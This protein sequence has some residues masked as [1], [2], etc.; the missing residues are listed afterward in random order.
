MLENLLTSPIPLA[1]VVIVLSLVIFFALVM[2]VRKLAV[3]ANTKNTANFI[4][5]GLSALVGIIVGFLLALTIGQYVEILRSRFTLLVGAG[6][7][8]YLWYRFGDQNISRQ[9]QTKP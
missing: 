1:A 8:V 9:R 3:D 7:Y 4:G 5:Y 2:I 6:I